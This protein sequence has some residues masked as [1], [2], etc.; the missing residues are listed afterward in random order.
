MDEATVRNGGADRLGRTFRLSLIFT[1]LLFCLAGAL[2]WIVPLELGRGLFAFPVLTSSAAVAG[3]LLAAG[4][5]GDCSRTPPTIVFG[6]FVFLVNYLSGK[7]TGFSWAEV[8]QVMPG[9]KRIKVGPGRHFN[10]KV[11][12]HRKK[13]L[14]IPNLSFEA[15]RALYIG[16]N[17]RTKRVPPVEARKMADRWFDIK[18]Y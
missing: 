16:F 5:M 11:V 4:V 14:V 13:D 8:H 12:A 3:L 15:A 9:D 2:F 17:E 10:V 7:S 1:V 18:R 6:P